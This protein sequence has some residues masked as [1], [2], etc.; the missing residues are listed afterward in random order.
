MNAQ[1]WQQKGGEE[2]PMNDSR[3]GEGAPINRGSKHK[4]RRRYFFLPREGKGQRILTQAVTVLLIGVFLFSAGKLISY[5]AEYLSA[6]NLSEDLRQTYHAEKE[7]ESLSSPSPAATPEGTPLVTTTHFM[8]PPGTNE[9][10]PTPTPAPTA[11]ARLSPMPYPN[12][13]YTIM[14][15]RFTKLRR[16]NEDI[17]GWL[18]VKG[19][20]DE[21]VVQRDN[22]YYLRRDYKGYHNN[23]GAIFLD[24][25]ADLRTRPYTLMLYGHNMKTGLMFG[26]LRNYEDPG[27]YRSNAFITFDSIYEDGRYV[28]FAVGTVSTDPKNWRYVNWSHLNSTS[29]TNREGAIASLQRF[30]VYGKYIDVRADDQLLLLITCVDEETD[31]RVVAARRIRDDETE[32]ELNALVQKTRKK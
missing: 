3:Q 27:Y 7:Q 24:E 19:V 10:T 23:N 18:T 12:N 5:G 15:S 14:N 9:T 13:P 26:K 11:V 32:A 30:S 6:R 25:S 29:V 28:I 22:Q 21:P 1:S 20:V 16:Q 8:T 31:R 2:M 17:I 4:R